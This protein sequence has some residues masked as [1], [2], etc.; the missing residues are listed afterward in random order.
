MTPFERTQQYIASIDLA[1]VQLV[2]LG[3]DAYPTDPTGVAFCKTTWDAMTRGN[4]SGRHVLEALGVNWKA[5]EHRQPEHLPPDLFKR[6]ARAGVVFLNASYLP[7]KGGRF[8]RRADLD[9]LTTAYKLNSSILSAAT[10]VIRCGEAKRMDWVPDVKPEGKFR[11]VV[12]PGIRNRNSKYKK[13]EWDVLWGKTG[14][15]ASKWTNTQ[16]ILVTHR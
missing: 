13:D 5:E 2:I 6:L 9:A 4:C 1:L 14:S 11:D 8:T 15:L 12:H 10:T 16:N 7:A 3:K